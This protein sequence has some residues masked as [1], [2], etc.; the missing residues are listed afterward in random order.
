MVLA[1]LGR[2]GGIARLVPVAG[3]A[4]GAG[5]REVAQRVVAPA[6]LLQHAG[7]GGQAAHG[8]QSGLGV[9]AQFGAP[10]RFVLLGRGIPAVHLDDA[11]GLVMLPSTP[12]WRYTA[13]TSRMPW[14]NS[15]ELFRRGED[16]G[17]SPTV[18]RVA[19]A[20]ASRLGLAA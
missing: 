2:I 16:E 9:V 11:P 6:L 1:G 3:P 20:A 8:H 5:F 17:W 10:A 4:A 12:E 19:Q 14:Y 18:R 7:V 13:A 15:V